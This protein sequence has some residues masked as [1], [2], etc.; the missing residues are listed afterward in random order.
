MSEPQFLAGIIQELYTPQKQAEKKFL[1]QAYR[2]GYH[3]AYDQALTDVFILLKKGMSI[4]EVHALTALQTNLIGAWRTES[5]D[6]FILP[7]PFNQRELQETLAL[8]RK[9]GKA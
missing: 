7:P 1:V 3:Q 9:V 8:R 4:D 5:A 2:N 6:C